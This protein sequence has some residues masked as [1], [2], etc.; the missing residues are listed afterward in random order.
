MKKIETFLLLFIRSNNEQ[1]ATSKKIETFLKLFIR[2][3]NEQ[4]AI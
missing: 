3:N 2:S 1:Q 4:Q